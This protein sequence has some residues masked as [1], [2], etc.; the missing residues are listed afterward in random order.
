MTSLTTSSTNNA[1][2][3]ARPNE[4]EFI[5]LGT[6]CSSALPLVKCVTAS[7]DVPQCRTCLSTLDP[8]GR[9]NMRR[10]TSAVVRVKS[11]DS[12]GK[13]ATIVIDV[14][15]TFLPSALEW[16]PKYGLRKIDGVLITHAHADAM[17]GLDDLRGW[18]LDGGIQTHIDL[19][20]SQTTFDEIRRSFPYLIAREFATGGGDVPE[21][22]WHIIEDKV[23]FKVGNT[24]VTI[25]PFAVHHGRVFSQCPSE[26]LPTPVYTSPPTPV[27]GRSSPQLPTIPSLSRIH[28]NDPYLCMGF[29]FEEALVYISDVSHIPEDVWSL[30][31]AP[32]VF[33]KKTHVAPVFVLDCL[34]IMP[35]TSHFGLK[36]AIDAV[37]R[38]GARRNY[39]YAEIL[40]SVGE[41]K[42][43]IANVS[44]AVRKGMEAVG[45]GEAQWVRPAF[46]G[47]RVFISPDGLVRDDENS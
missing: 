31:L 32:K 33:G 13:L 20:A 41:E 16:F 35:H 39:L 27:S 37:R 8:A 19:Y 7:P 1:S 18:T 3:A 44:E 23:P 40:R 43:D 9:K 30:L 38:M 15:K 12:D 28:S 4:L 5:F 11:A 22:K 34:R 14:G 26:G 42:R 17:N 25:T 29:K 45:E 21:F 46:D 2:S 36:Q 24:G 10:N 47:L 6:G